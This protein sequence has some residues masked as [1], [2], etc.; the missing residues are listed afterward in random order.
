MTFSRASLT[1]FCIVKWSAVKTYS[2]KTYLYSPYKN[3]YILP[4]V[5]STHFMWYSVE[6]NPKID[7]HARI[8]M[9]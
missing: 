6:M 7:S 9:K 5:H 2:N 8:E 3:Y 4:D 1:I